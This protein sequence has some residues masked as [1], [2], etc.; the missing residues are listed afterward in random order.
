[1]SFSDLLYQR[2]K[3]LIS[4][5]MFL[6]TSKSNQI[7]S[8]FNYILQSI[9]QVTTVQLYFT[10]L[11]NAITTLLLSQNPVQIFALPVITTN[12]RL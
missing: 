6:N 1:M 4:L 12:K 5:K 7:I 11:A 9:K 3:L 10:T 8:I 2:S